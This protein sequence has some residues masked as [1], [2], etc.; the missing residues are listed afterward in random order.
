[1]E[2][3]ITNLKTDF[4]NISLIRGK[5]INIFDSLKNKTDKLKL[6]YSEFIRHS[7]S[8]LFI[9][10]LDSFHFQSKLI[11]LENDDMKRMFLA[12]NNRMYCEYFKLY[13][14]IVSYVNEN[15]NDK[16]ILETIKG[17]NFPIY[18]DLEPFKDYKFEITME[19]HDNII[20]LLN[21]IVSIVNNR[22]NELSLHKSKQLIGLNIDNFVN[23]FNF[24]IT[25]MKE[26]IN[27][28]LS[29]MEFFHKLHNKYLK[30]FS[31]KIQLMFNHI[32]SDIQFDE[33]IENSNIVNSKQ[34]I[35]DVVFE[36]KTNN[37]DLPKIINNEIEN[38][39]SYDNECGLNTPT[40]NSVGSDIS[41]ESKTSSL[42]G[43]FK[44][45]M[46]KIIKNGI[47][48]VNNIINGCNIN[49]SIENKPNELV[50]ENLLNKKPQN[51]EIFL[52]DFN[53]NISDIDIDLN[54]NIFLKKDENGVVVEEQ[55]I[56][57]VTVV[58]E[59]LLAVE[60]PLL[61][62]EEADVD[63]NYRIIIGNEKETQTF[64]EEP[65]VEEPVVEAVAVVEEPVVE[66]PVVEA[67]AVVEEPVVEEPVI[68]EVSVVEE[69]LLA[70]EEPIMEEVAVVE[71]PVVVVEETVV[72]ETVVE[73]PLVEEPVVEETIVEETVVEEPI[74]EEVSVV[75]EPL[76]AVEEPVVEEVSV[77][78]EPVVVVEETV[79]EETV[80]EET[81]VEEP[82]VEETVVEETVVEETVVEETVVE[83]P[84]VEETIVEETV[85]E[86]PIMEEVA[87]V[88]EPVVEEPVVEE[89]V[90][91]EPVVEETVVEE[92]VVEET[93]VE[94]E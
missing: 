42:N 77:V 44:I 2:G 93:V 73:E 36:I 60:E 57:E 32:N 49:N 40:N 11:D 3:R 22:E 41:N 14:I 64:F 63:I 48:K 39:I 9:F 83:E 10:G 76:L 54:E 88:E 89:S 90:V 37:N 21:S 92:P 55:V 35:D 31:N 50:L 6:L 74:M 12:I 84:V 70:V 72:E 75:E 1:M 53:D 13:K 17:N 82:V 30:R 58:E 20:L 43:G 59:P 8:Q 15:I 80:V 18:K 94:E 46:P 56:E 33:N 69:P 45:K 38:I 19:I 51:M 67:V 78:E 5:I 91:E 4:N 47:R 24:E 23:S 62:V 29:Y 7:N 52:N 27:L 28:F 85:V 66:E 68:E 87:V 79:V 71:E 34:E 65:V 26:K 16:K 61:A 86:E 81:V 25:I